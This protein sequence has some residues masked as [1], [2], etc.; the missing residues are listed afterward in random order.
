MAHTADLDRMIADL[1]LPVGLRVRTVRSARRLVLSLGP[2]ADTARLTVP[3]GISLGAVEGFL[4]QRRG[5]LEERLAEAPKPVPFEPGAVIPILG[6]DRYLRHDPNHRGALAIGPDEIIV[7][8]DIRYMR[9]RVRDGL[10]THAR[11]TLS[12]RVTP[13]ARQVGREIRRVSVRDTRSRWGSCSTEGNLSFSWRLIFAPAEV[14]DYVGAHEVAHLV[15]HDHSRRFWAL[16]EEL[17]PDYREPQH[18]LKVHGRGL[19]R[20]GAQPE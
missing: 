8:G 14:L 2:S 11:R 15:H 19:H 5:W 12:E 16:V 7:G 9:R 10:V 17:M 1:D 3:S 4:E 20:Y 6:R 13:Y 18:W